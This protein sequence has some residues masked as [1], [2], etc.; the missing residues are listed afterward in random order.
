MS[1][2]TYPVFS[3]NKCYTQPPKKFIDFPETEQTVLG[4]FGLKSFSFG[5]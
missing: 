1:D 4:L 3:C 2:T 5:G